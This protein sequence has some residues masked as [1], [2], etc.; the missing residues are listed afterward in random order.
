M[1]KFS[2]DLSPELQEK[3]KAIAT[4]VGLKA[5]GINVEA[6]L[7]K[8]SKKDYG[9]VLKG[10]DLVE[11]FTGD[12]S[13]V[14]IA[15]YEDLFDRLDEGVQDILIR[16][17]I[18]RVWYDMDKDKIVINKPEL[19]IPLGTYKKYGEEA[20]NAVEVV[21]HTLQQMAEEKK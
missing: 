10:N 7:M 5:N 1:G 17:L 18:D 12:N 21:Y 9:V 15:I 8:K 2:R 13:T 3:V 4:E 14:V 11:L 19:Q 6:V 16:S 20:V